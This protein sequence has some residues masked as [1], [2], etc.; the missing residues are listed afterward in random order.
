MRKGISREDFIY[1]YIL[2]RVKAGNEKSAWELQRVIPTINEIYDMVPR[3]LSRLN[4]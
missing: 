3:E 1:E 2:S 4:Q